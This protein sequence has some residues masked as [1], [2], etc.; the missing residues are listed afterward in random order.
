MGAQKII[1]NSRPVTIRA[2][3]QTTVS[4]I[5]NVIL[6][7][8]LWFLVVPSLVWIYKC[9]VAASIVWI[10]KCFVPDTTPADS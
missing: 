4:V 7:A 9:F 5:T 10:Y 3:S 2:R 1:L 8:L 6:Q